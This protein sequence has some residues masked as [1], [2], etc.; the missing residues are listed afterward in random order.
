M[1]HGCE[2]KNRLANDVDWPVIPQK[3][4]FESDSVRLYQGE[5]LELMQ[6]MQTTEQSKFDA[7]ITDPPY[8]SGAANMT[9]A[10]VSCCRCARPLAC[11][12]VKKT[13]L[14]QS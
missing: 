2:N 1:S 8:C 12:C 13:A 3:P 11:M 7:V 5:C 6:Q 9:G 14:A 4:Y 10:D